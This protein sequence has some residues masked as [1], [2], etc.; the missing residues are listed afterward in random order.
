MDVFVAQVSAIV[1]FMTSS[2]SDVAPAAP[3]FTSATAATAVTSTALTSVDASVVDDDRRPP[4]IVN[5]RP[6]RVEPTMLTRRASAAVDDA[7][8]RMVPGNL[9]RRM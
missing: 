3:S 8:G 6:P 5:A 7:W 2:A 4:M 9:L 1:Q